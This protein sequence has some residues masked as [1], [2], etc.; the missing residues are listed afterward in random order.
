MCWDSAPRRMEL[1][2]AAESLHCIEPSLENAK[3]RSQWIDEPRKQKRLTERQAR[4]AR[5]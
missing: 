4:L 2:L 5:L 1:R 3:E